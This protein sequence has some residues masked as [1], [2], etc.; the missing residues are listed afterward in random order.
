MGLKVAVALGAALGLMA[1]PAMGFDLQGHRGARGLAPEN[2]LA[3]FQRALGIGVTTLE[4]DLGLTRDGVLVV[5]HDLRLNPDIARRD[6]AYVE[7]PGPAIRSLTLEEL[8]FYD[9]GR[10]R[11]DSAYA[12]GFPG[13]VPVD[14]APVPTLAE[15][16]DL[17]RGHPGVRLNIETKITPTSGLDAPDAGTFAN[18]V[19]QAV[20]GSGMADRVTVQSFDWRTLLVLRGIAPEIRRACVTGEG[21]PDTVGRR[22]G[23]AS[24]WTAG[25]ALRDFGDSTPRMAGA[26]GCAVWSP[27]W[28]D[29]TQDKVAEAQGLGMEVI[30]WTVNERA[31]MERLIGWGVDGIITDYPDRLRAVM[32]AHK[33]DLPKRA[34]GR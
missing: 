24:P 16:F 23:K 28:R 15:V 29:L 32:A 1:G 5:H 2:T 10:V 22:S 25:F 13:Q 3:G 20:R 21:N 6:G 12:R 27:A 19:A 30:P 8:R 11:P 4:L 34:P 14:G 18:A 17:V 26:A 31:D 9:V 33:M 7:A